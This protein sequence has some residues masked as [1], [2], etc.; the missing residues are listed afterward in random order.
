LTSS[1]WRRQQKY[2]VLGLLLGALL[3]GVIAGAVGGLLSPLP[4]RIRLITLTGLLVVILPFELAGRPLSL[5]QN[6]RAVPQTI[7]PRSRTDGPL[8]FG[9]EMGTGLRTF[10][11]TALPHALLTT[12]LL[13]G[14]PVAGLLAG[15][16]FAAGRAMMPMIRS[17][18]PRPAEWDDVLLHRLSLIGRLCAAGFALVVVGLPAVEVLTAWW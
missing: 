10:M 4:A 12:V 13:A 16:G 18:H 9:F 2:F 7:I 6:R 14:D 5:P 17:H 1:V 15:S 3:T 11:P 8:Q